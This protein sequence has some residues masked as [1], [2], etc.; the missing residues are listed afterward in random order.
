MTLEEYHSTWE[1][2]EAEHYS[3]LMKHIYQEDQKE[4][5]DSLAGKAGKVN[6]EHAV[7]MDNVKSLIAFNHE[8]Y[9]KEVMTLDTTDMQLNQLEEEVQGHLHSSDKVEGPSD[10]E[11]SDRSARLEVDNSEDEG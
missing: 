11:A 10:C 9:N 4:Y 1:L 2:K 8:V 3:R 6:L 5:G 7:E